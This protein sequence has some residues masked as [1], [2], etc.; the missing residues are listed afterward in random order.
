MAYE[1]VL[2]RRIAAWYNEFPMEISQTGDTSLK[3]KTKNTT[4]AV[5]PTKIDSDVVILTSNEVVDIPDTVKVVIDGPGEYEV[6]G[7]S[8]R[9]E[10]VSGQLLY[11]IYDDQYK[12][13][14]T[15]STLIS[16]LKDE[17]GYDALVIKV[18]GKLDNDMLNVSAS[19][20]LVLYGKHVNESIPSGENTKRMSRV[21]LKKK[22]E[23]KGFVIVLSN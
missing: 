19:D 20:T 9:G 10:R 7:V 17:E 13:I 21:N 15:P 23:I 22:D 4:L 3:I 11:H 16:T 2:D 6:A 1:A 14:L 18:D 12:V 8:V 5:D